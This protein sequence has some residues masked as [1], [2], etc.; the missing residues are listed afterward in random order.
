MNSR[1]VA[2]KEKLIAAR[3]ALNQALDGVGDR[4][5]TQIYSDGAQWTARELLIHL[6]VAHTGQV[7]VMQRILAGEEG[8]PENFDLERYNRSSVQKRIETTPEEARAVLNQSHE[9]LLAWL[10]TLTDEQL[11]IKGRHASGQVLSIEQFLRFGF[12]K[13]ERD[14]AADIARTLGIEA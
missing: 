10:D 4:W 13:H 6:M 7:G 12:A 9:D 5:D 2:L 1:I 8:V 14:H 11:D 3:E